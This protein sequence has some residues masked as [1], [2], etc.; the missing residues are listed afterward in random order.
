MNLLLLLFIAFH[1]TTALLNDEDIQY[2][3]I[4]VIDSYEDEE[5]DSFDQELLAEVRRQ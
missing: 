2:S 4:N 5:T 3:G 1:T